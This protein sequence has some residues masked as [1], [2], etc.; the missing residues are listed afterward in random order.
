MRKI[1]KKFLKGKKSFLVKLSPVDSINNTGSFCVFPDTVSFSGQDKGESV[2]LIVRKHPAVFIPRYLAII[3]L[4]LTPLLFFAA[5]SG[6]GDFS[7]IYNFGVG[8]LFLLLAFTVACDTYFKWYYSVNIITD[9]RIVDV[10]FNNIL[11]H[12]FSEA[13]LD[14]I[15]DVSHSPAG[16][17]SSIFDYGDVY[18]QTAGSKP[19]FEFTGVPRPR[20][21]Q[22]TL[23]D[24]LEMKKKGHI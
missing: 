21:I 18:I 16:V 14:K 6:T 17:L 10:D 9:I 5:F 13:H 19:E 24:L 20:D 8:L 12:R 22:D 15:E 3:G 4:L 11:F 7:P 1:P 2:V 23:L